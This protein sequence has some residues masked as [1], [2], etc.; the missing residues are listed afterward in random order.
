M[1]STADERSTKFTEGSLLRP[2]LSLAAPLMVTQLLQVLYNL[3]DTFW[4]GRLGADAVS[5]LSFSWPLVYLLIGVASG[6]TNAGTILIS[7]HAG[8]GNETQVR[9]VA[10]HTLSLNL[11]FSVVLAVA[12][13]LLTPPLLDL[14]GTAPGTAIHDLAVRYARILFL[15]FPLTFGYFVFQSLLRGWGNTKTPMYPTIGT[16][17]LNVLLDPFFVFG[18]D[19]NPLFDLL[20]VGQP[21]HPLFVVTGFAGFGVEGAA[22]AT[23]LSQALAA[24]VGLWFLFSG[25]TEFTLSRAD[26][27]LDRT[28]AWEITRIGAP[29]SVEQVTNAVSVIAMTALIAFTG[30]AAVAAYGIGDRYTSLVWLPTVAMGMA[31]ETV[32]GQNLGKGRSDRARRTVYFA[33]GILA[34]AFLVVGGLTVLFARPLVSLLITG[35]GSDAVVRYEVEYLRIAAPTWA[36]VVVFHMMNGAFCGAGSTRLSMALNVG[37]Q[38]G[39]RAVVAA[40]LVLGVGLGASGVWYGIAVSNVVA[41]VLGSIF[42]FRGDWLTGA[43]EDDIPVVD[44]GGTQTG[45]SE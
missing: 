40:I 33:I 23:V 5:A 10:G 17:V 18:F 7:Q 26:L 27:G 13:V 35:E 2:L 22:I 25:R 15:G 4:I 43:V 38:W 16:V 6:F 21:L 14:I 12:G 36:I 28:L 39:L 19:H 8:S 11:F 31:V 44:T 30:T 1:S 45:T 32:V 3:T 9:R 42:F 20:P 37:T 34:A 29:L 41:A 24:A